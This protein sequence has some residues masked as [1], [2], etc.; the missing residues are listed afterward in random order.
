MMKRKSYSLK[1]MHGIHKIWPL[2]FWQ[3]CFI[4][5]MEVRREWMWKIYSH[6]ILGYMPVGIYHYY[7]FDCCPTEEMAIKLRN[8]EESIWNRNQ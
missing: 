4:C 1:P 7:C 5:H 3:E 2:F 8:S 6:T